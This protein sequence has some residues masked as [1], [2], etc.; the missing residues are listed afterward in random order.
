MNRIRV[1]VRVRRTWLLSLSYADTAGGQQSEP[2]E[3]SAQS[4]AMLV[5]DL[6]GSEQ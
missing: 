2:Q 6:L 5:P 1:L 4:L 3:G